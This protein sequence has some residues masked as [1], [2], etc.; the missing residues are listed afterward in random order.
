M[1][2]VPTCYQLGAPCCNNSHVGLRCKTSWAW[3]F[4]A[5]SM[6]SRPAAEERVGAKGCAS[7]PARHNDHSSPIAAM[8]SLTVMSVIA[9][10]V[11]LESMQGKL[12][13]ASVRATLAACV[14]LAAFGVSSLMGASMCTRCMAIPRL[15]LG[16]TEH[17]SNSTACD[18]TSDRPLLLR[19][20]ATM[21]RRWCSCEVAPRR[22][23]AAQRL[24]WLR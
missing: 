21:L 12:L 11:M 22:R 19:N 7:G 4:P 5:T 15:A 1:L 10:T 17:V 23:S 20:H 18:Y 6:E 2:L 14:R 24:P 16:C 13:S 9:M 3:A 8:T